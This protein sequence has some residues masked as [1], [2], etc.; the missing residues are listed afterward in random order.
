[1]I[2]LRGAIPVIAFFALFFFPWPVSALL[3]FLSALAFPL[4]GLL[5]GAFADILYFTPGAANVPFFL[6]FGAA[7]TLISILV[8]RFV[9]TRI[10]EG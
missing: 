9:K 10:M 6:L 4:A 8:H 3:V 2:L 7:A 1:M 5:L